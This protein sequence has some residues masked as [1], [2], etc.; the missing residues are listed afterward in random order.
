MKKNK[1]I[2]W[3]LSLI[4]SGKVFGADPV[5]QPLRI[6]LSKDEKQYLQFTLL[7]QVWLRGNESNAGTTVLG[8]LQK[9]T[10]DLGLRRT[11][12]QLFGEIAP[13]TFVYFQWGQ[14]NFNRT[15]GWPS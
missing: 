2:I 7:N 1:I 6:P 9:N 8:E 11:R 13:K 15:D 3:A 4:F 10:V 14:N 12:F 5:P